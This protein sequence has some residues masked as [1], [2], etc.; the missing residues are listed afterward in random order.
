MH[1]FD[2]KAIFDPPMFHINHGSKGYGGGGI[3]D[4]ENKMCNDPVDA[5]QQQQKTQNLE[6]WGFGDLEVEYETI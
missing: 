5:I 1:G 6:S 3:I 2:L 4:G